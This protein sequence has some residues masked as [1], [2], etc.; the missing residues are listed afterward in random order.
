MPSIFQ[1]RG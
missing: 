1:A